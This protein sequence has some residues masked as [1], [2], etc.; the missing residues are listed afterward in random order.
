MEDQNYKILEQAAQNIDASYA[1]ARDEEV[2]L[3]QEAAESL[4]RKQDRRVRPKP[5]ARCELRLPLPLY[6]RLQRQA[7]RQNKSM[8]Q[9]ITGVLQEAQNA[10]LPVAGPKSAPSGAQSQ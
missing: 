6:K 3:R 7:R 5:L 4:G 9:Y 1:R 8:N 2:R 10:N